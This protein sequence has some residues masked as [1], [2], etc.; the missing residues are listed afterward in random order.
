MNVSHSNAKP[1]LKWAGGKSQLVNEIRRSLPSDIS[2]FKELV[3]VEPFVGSGAV[4]FWFMRTHKNVKKAI[5]NDINGSICAAYKTI[6]DHHEELIQRL[7]ELQNEYRALENVIDQKS[8]FLEA[9]TNFNLGSTND[10]EN[11]AN[12]IFLNRTCF[13]GLY[14][15]NSKGKFNVPFGRYKNPRICDK[16]TIQADS[17][18]LQDVEILNC[19]YSATLQRVESEKH[20]FFYFDPPYKPISKTSSFNA[21]SSKTFDDVEQGRLRNFCNELNRRSF[22][23]LL[24]N[25]DL[26][27][28]NNE[29]HYFDELYNGFHIRRVDARRNINSKSS[30]RGTIKELLIS[31][32]EQLFEKELEYELPF[33]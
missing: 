11:T 26:K 24:S 1:F 3:Y 25:S 6:R 28:T 32:Y 7:T 13:N 16:E 18:I 31:N 17:R 4:F 19:D 21:Y 5:I 29:D 8:Y 27:N 12:L 30:G 10:V 14:R 33:Q 9:R 2:L 20:V 15:V 22:Y 23:W